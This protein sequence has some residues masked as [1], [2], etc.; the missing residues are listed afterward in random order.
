MAKRALGRGLSAL[1]GDA[2]KPGAMAAAAAAT[3]SSTDGGAR[4]SML[5]DRE[6]VMLEPG[7][8]R[9]NP[10]QPRKSMDRQALEELSASISVNG[11]IQPILVRK[12][13]SDF[14][15]VAG[16]RRLQASRMAGLTAIPALVCTMAEEESLRLALLENIQR[17]DL[18]AMEEAEAYRSIMD[19]LGATHRE[20]ADMLGKSRS[21]VTNMLRL[22]NLE[23]SI[24]SAV[25][26]GALSMGHARCLLAV[27]NPKQRL[28]LARKAEG[29]GLSV[30]ALERKVQALSGRQE[31]GRPRGKG[32]DQ[33]HDPDEV[34][35]REFETRLQHYLGSPVKIRR[36]GKKGRVEI[37]FFSD[38]E[39]ERVLERV[40][41]S[42]QL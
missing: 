22:L 27:D 23:A 35:L 40:G 18:N 6:A 19:H 9:A 38:A 12:V 42:P 25:A 10:H 15:L 24:R 32:L 39:L 21:T 17:E 29:G 26:S 33:P 41:V 30:R 7:L 16:E 8:I 31:A 36:R 28:R 1:L 34:A 14:E 37:A 13:G 3:S 11:V 5:G 2:A 20:V 4:A